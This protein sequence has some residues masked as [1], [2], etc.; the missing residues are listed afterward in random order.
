M[1]LVYPLAVYAA[2]QSHLKQPLVF[3]GDF[4]AWDK[5]QIQ[6]SA[7]LNSYMSEWAALTPEA[8]NHA[9]NAGD[10]FPFTWSRFWPVLAGWYG[11]GWAP[12][13]ED[14]EYKTM[15]SPHAPRG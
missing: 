5:E 9:F 15:Q 8:E 14:A 1:N 3:P 4:A 2:V 7:M 6:S 12:P 10:A 11:V 13:D